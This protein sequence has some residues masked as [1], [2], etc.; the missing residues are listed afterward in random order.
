M[1]WPICCYLWGCFAVTIREIRTENPFLGQSAV[2]WQDKDVLSYPTYQQSTEL[3]TKVVSDMCSPDRNVTCVHNKFSNS[4]NQI[5]FLQMVLIGELKHVNG[6]FNTSHHLSRSGH[7]SKRALEG[8]GK[9][10]RLDIHPYDSQGQLLRTRADF[11]WETLPWASFVCFSAMQ[12][13]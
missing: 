11:H 13:L 2:S 12:S 4:H 8:K 9:K 6:K 10:Q 7:W 5:I 3:F 1:F